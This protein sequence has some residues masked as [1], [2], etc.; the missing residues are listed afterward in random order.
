M[1]KFWLMSWNKGFRFMLEF[2]II[3]WNCLFLICRFKWS[4]ICWICFW[5][6][7]KELCWVVD[8]NVLLV[9]VC[10]IVLVWLWLRLLI[11]DSV[12]RVVMWLLG[13][14]KFVVL[15]NRCGNDCR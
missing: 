4:L 3:C 7:I 14:E 15:V 13:L 5:L 10:W 9:V 1:D 11:E 6:C 8:E 12:D 2:I